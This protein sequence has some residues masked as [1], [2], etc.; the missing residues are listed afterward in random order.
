M[1]KFKSML[2]VSLTEDDQ[3]EPSLPTRNSA[4]T[5]RLRQ[6]GAGYR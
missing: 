1:M 3:T 6:P 4:P 5:V 2:W